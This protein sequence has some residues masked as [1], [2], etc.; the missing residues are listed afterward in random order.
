MVTFLP[1]FRFD[2]LLYKRTSLISSVQSP[3]IYKFHENPDAKSLFREPDDAF[4]VGLPFLFVFSSSSSCCC[5][6]LTI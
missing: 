1:R 3:D 4:I 6:I 5:I 2:N